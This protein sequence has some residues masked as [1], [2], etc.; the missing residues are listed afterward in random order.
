MHTLHAL[1]H[2][3]PPRHPPKL[4]HP[5]HNHPF[6]GTTPAHHHLHQVRFAALR[7]LGLRRP[8]GLKFFAHAVGR[9]GS[10]SLPRLGLR[11]GPVH[12]AVARVALLGVLALR[13]RAYVDVHAA[14][15]GQ[16]PREGSAPAGEPLGLLEASG[17][18]VLDRGLRELHRVGQH[19]H[20]HA[21]GVVPRAGVRL[22]GPEVTAGPDGVADRQP[23][24]AAGQG[25][26]EGG[27]VHA[28][29]HP[30]AIRARHRQADAG[31][32]Y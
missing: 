14:S 11:L 5:S 32:P 3:P 7:I 22:A 2:R 29:R 8:Q 30:A 26:R 4:N 28:G 9:H 23:A 13:R 24:A 21:V 18:A 15:V 17:R 31:R 19:R 16:S 27:G 10:P 12:R 25:R 1:C 6:R 20:P